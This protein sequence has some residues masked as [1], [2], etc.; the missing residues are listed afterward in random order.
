MAPRFAIIGFGEAGSNIAKTLREVG[1]DGIATYDILLDDPN[2]RPA[3][4]QKAETLGATPH[5]T[6]SDAVADADIV[7]STVVCKASLPVAQEAAKHLRPEQF[8]VDF[9]SISP[10]L[11][12]QVA[13]TI[14]GGGGRFVEASVMGGFPGT[15]HRA[16][17][18]LGGADAKDY[19]ALIAPLDF[20]V[21]FVQD[22]VG[23]ASAIKMVRSI[24]MK[25]MESLYLE[26]MRAANHFGIEQRVLD[27]IDKSTAGRS[28]TDG[29]NLTMPRTAVHAGRRA[30]EMA[31]V[32]LTLQEIGM[33]PTMAQATEKNLR[34][35]ADLGLKEIYKDRQAEGYDEVLAAIRDA[36]SEK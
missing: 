4:L 28:A 19:M 25:G 10:G 17:T 34:W 2:T 30:D 35:C 12:R 14:A 11:K 13:E 5:D 21:D 26:C 7:F 29:A 16:P 8:Y 22:D 32:A 6:L 1:V 20:K 36:N 23:L 9:N 18:L 27:T 24:M 33:E 3:M 15:G 31:Q